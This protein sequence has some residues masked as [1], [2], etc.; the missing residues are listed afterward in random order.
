MYNK[1]A[2]VSAILIIASIALF[3]ALI[4]LIPIAFCFPDGPRVQAF[5]SDPGGYTRSAI[6]GVWAMFIW[7]HYI[8]WPNFWPMYIGAIIFVVV[9]LIFGIMMLKQQRRNK[10]I[11]YNVVTL[12]T[13]FLA[14]PLLAFHVFMTFIMVSMGTLGIFYFGFGVSCA[15]CYIAAIVAQ[16]VTIVRLRRSSKEDSTTSKTD[17]D[18]TDTR[19]TEQQ[20]T[21]TT[22]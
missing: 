7:I 17:S 16:I 18:S 4:V 13:I 3:L 2:K 15:L 19:N 9:G 14:L 6:K 11:R 1:K 8:L 12:V 21:T 22:A 20:L 10:L 5:L